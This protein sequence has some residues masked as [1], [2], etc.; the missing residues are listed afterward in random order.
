M[1][2]QTHFA[3]DVIYSETRR[4]PV[5]DTLPILGPRVMAKALNTKQDLQSLNVVIIR[6]TQAA[7]GSS[8]GHLGCV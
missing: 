2:K 1:A 7:P 4:S 5:E 6:E 8:I 3:H